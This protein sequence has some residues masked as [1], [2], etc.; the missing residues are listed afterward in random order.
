[1][2]LSVLDFHDP[3]GAVD[4]APELEVLGY[5]RYWFG[6]HHSPEQCANPLLL[7]AI[8]ALTTNKLRLGSGGVCLS[9]HKPYKIAEDAG[10][11]EFLLP[12][13][14]D[15]G[16]TRG[17]PIEQDLLSAF[18]DVQSSQYENFSQKLSDLHGL[19]TGRF[20]PDHPFYGRKPYFGSAPPMWVLGLSR[21]SALWAANHGTGFCFSLHHAPVDVDGPM[22]VN[23]YRRNFTASP[24]FPEPAIIVVVSGA[25]LTREEVGSHALRSAN[26]NTGSRE[27]QREAR[28]TLTGSPQQCV[29][30]LL[31]IGEK[32]NTNE[33]M[34]LD[35]LGNQLE[36]RIEMYRSIGQQFGLKPRT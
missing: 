24:E 16:V 1:M 20:L 7:G 13:R 18:V 9:L 25:C 10:L 23:E 2:E 6:E 36:A 15:L 3:A 33:V 34:I 12:N 26:L 11:I 22:I 30:T 14:F 28:H 35:L 31:Y 27:L 32:F 5:K 8:L 4:L 17:L 19:L 29:E 21:E